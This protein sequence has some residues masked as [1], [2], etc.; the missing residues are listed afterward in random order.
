MSVGCSS[1]GVDGETVDELLL[2]ADRAMY[3]DKA[4]RKAVFAE[5]NSLTTNDLGQYRVM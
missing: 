1:F 5:S 3:A 4:R 2:A